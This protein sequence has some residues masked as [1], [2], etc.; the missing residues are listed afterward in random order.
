M[1]A[2][3]TVGYGEFADGVLVLAPIDHAEPLQAGA[4]LDLHI[5]ITGVDDDGEPVVTYRFRARPFEEGVRHA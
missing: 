5:G 3:M 4:T 2:P 1:T